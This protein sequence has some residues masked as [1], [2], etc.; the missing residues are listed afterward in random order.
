MELTTNWS[1]YAVNLFLES[2]LKAKII[3]FVPS[4]TLERHRNIQF[5]DVKVTNFLDQTFSI[6]EELISNKFAISEKNIKKFKANFD[7]TDIN[8][9]ERWNDNSQNGGVLINGE[10]KIVVDYNEEIISRKYQEQL[11]KHNIF[12]QRSIVKVLEW[13]KKI[14]GFE[15]CVPDINGRLS[16]LDMIEALLKQKR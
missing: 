15:K 14:H 5:G 6:T 2:I 7:K 11:I 4:Q 8:H 13:K 16:Y 10:R 9:I 12:M 3:E 1:E